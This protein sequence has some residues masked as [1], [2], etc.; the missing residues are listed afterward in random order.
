ME[1]WH[2]NSYILSN[3]W[4]HE[5]RLKGQREKWKTFLQNTNSLNLKAEFK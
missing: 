4:G 2:I 3:I 5:R 1:I